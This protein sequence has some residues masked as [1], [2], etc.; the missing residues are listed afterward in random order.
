VGALLLCLSS[1]WPPE[2]YC[3]CPLAPGRSPVTRVCVKPKLHIHKVCG[4]RFH[5]LL[6]TSYT[7]DCLPTNILLAVGF[8]ILECYSSLPACIGYWQQWQEVW[9]S[10]QWLPLLA[11]ASLRALCQRSIRHVNMKQTS[12]TIGADC[13][14]LCIS[15]YF[16]NTMHL[17]YR[18]TWLAAVCCG[19]DARGLCRRS[20]NIKHWCM[21]E[22]YR[23]QTLLKRCCRE[24]RRPD[25]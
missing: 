5:P 1:R 9:G 25:T 8:R 15:R 16:V 7:M 2:L 14:H 11:I 19:S 18:D 24:L 6:H 20:E 22:Q 13:R 12:T 10:V 4:P 17:Q 3:W 21:R 23:W